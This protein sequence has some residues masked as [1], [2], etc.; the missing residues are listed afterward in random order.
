MKSFP[1]LSTK[2]LTLRQLED[3]DVKEIFLLRSDASI[4]KYLDRQ[5]C[6]TLED[7]SEFIE[8]IKSNNL[9]YWAISLK[10]NRKL[11]GT[12]C[13]FDI[14]EELQKCEIGYELLPEYQG[15]GIMEET[16]KGILEYAHQ[17]LKLKT[18]DAYSHKNNKGST[19]LLNKLKF[20]KMYDVESS[21]S[22]LVLF[23]LME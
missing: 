4:N 9:S 18:I 7:A 8:K 17:T 11:I 6:K 2:R 16:A 23:R 13:L 21:N 10:E 22:D 5:P 19:K 20:K 15:R 3:S 1:I 12:I 14:S